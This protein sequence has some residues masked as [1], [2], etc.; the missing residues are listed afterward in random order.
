MTTGKK[1]V[2]VVTDIVVCVC[3]GRR[4]GECGCCTERKR[5]QC[6]DE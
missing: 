5:K 4:D 1:M 6:G 2:V 3:S